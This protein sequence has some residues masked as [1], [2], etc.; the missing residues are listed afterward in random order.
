[1]V[2]A[3]VGDGLEVRGRATGEPHQ[4]DVALRLA[5][6][7]PTR[8]NLVEVAVDV[9]LQQHRRVVR[10][11]SGHR[12]LRP[13]EAELFEIQFIDEDVDD[14]N[15]V[16]LAEVVVETLGQQGD[17]GSV[18]ALDESL[19]VAAR[20]VA[21]TSILPRSLARSKRFHTASV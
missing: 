20:S 5:F 18:L 21:L 14:A 6:E 3:E 1:M 10:G 17:L 15:R 12:G 16:V 19:H 11:P 8:L 9:D 7:A 2:L 4:F 13:V